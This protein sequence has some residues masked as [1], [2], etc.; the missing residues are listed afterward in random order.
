MRRL[1]L[2]YQGGKWIDIAADGSATLKNRLNQNPAAATKRVENHFA[3][4]HVMIDERSGK[5][6]IDGRHIRMH[7]V[8]RVLSLH[9]IEVQV[10]PVLKA[11]RT[12]LNR[13][14]PQ[15]ARPQR[16]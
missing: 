5:R 15:A 12:S 4:R 10:V 11:C 16:Q 13:Q 8:G 1:C 9:T 7:R 6:R 2:R 14:A 3:F